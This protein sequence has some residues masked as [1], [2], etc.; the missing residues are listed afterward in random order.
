MR[1]FASLSLLAALSILPACSSASGENECRS[2]RARIRLDRAG[3]ARARDHNPA[4]TV[5]SC[6][7]NA[8]AEEGISTKHAVGATQETYSSWSMAGSMQYLECKRAE[9]EHISFFKQDI[10]LSLDE[11]C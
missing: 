3:A 8:A 4:A 2:R 10:R 9:G 1:V 7:P 5:R 11:R 6:T